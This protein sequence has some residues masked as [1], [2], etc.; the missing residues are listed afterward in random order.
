MK[1]V[2]RGRFAFGWVLLAVLGAGVLWRAH[3]DYVEYRVMLKATDELREACHE[4]GELPCF[5]V[6]LVN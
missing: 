4:S 3:G 6:A 2:R 1:N 5:E